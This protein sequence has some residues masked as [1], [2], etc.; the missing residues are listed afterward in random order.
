VTLGHSDS[1]ETTSVAIGLQRSKT[2]E[3]SVTRGHRDLTI[4]SHSKSSISCVTVPSSSAGTLFIYVDSIS[5]STSGD[6]NVKKN[7]NNAQ[8]K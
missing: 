2:Y 8:S 4:Y 1:V 7:K 6:T 5:T 3:A